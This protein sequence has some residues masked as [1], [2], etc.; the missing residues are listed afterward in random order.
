MGMLQ[1]VI[2]RYIGKN[3]DIKQTKSVAD[4]DDTDEYILGLS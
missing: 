1:C 2:E 4:G 3:Y